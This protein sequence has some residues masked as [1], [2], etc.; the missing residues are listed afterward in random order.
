VPIEELIFIPDNA[1]LYAAFGAAN[2]GIAE[3]GDVGRFP[4][5]EPLEHFIKHGR[6]AR[7]GEQAG[8]PLS[9]TANET[10]E[11]TDTYKI[12]KFVPA[13]FEKGQVVRGVIGLDGGSTSSKAVLIDEEGEILCKAYQLSK[14]NPIQDTKELLAE[15]NNHVT[16]QGATL[17][18]V[19]F[20]ATGYAADVLEECV[21]ADVNIVETVA[22]M[23]SAVH[24]FGD[25]DV[26][27]DIGGQD[28]KVLFMSRPARRGRP[29]G[30][31]CSRRS[32]RRS[33]PSARSWSSPLVQPGGWLV[34]I[35]VPRGRY[36]PVRAVPR[37]SVPHA[38]HRR[39]RR[40]ETWPAR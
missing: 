22:H 33:C 7:L 6:R 39:F 19:G 17:E 14:G 34:L 36:R 23:M 21:L 24:F 30:P 37:S 10:D 27:C 40:G 15:I 32:A 2:Y 35:P 9:A 12:P 28:I 3:G 4:G 25:V 11:F 20:G 38:P 29:A 1:E 31:R 13:T 26:I 18:C 16:G 5:V 8:P